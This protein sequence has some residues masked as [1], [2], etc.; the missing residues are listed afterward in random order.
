MHRAA[1]SCQTGP[2]CA[3]D[4]VAVKPLSPKLNSGMVE[5]RRELADEIFRLLDRDGDGNLNAQ[6]MQSF[7]VHT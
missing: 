4:H 3:A 2:G 6:E 5:T 1:I 7:A